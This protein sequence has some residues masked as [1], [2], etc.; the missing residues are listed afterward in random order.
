MEPSRLRRPQLRALAERSGASF[1]H[2]DGGIE[3]RSGL[4]EAQLSRDVVLFP[5]DCVRHNA[6]AT[7]KRVSRYAGEPYFAL[8]SS[9][10]TSLA[11]GLHKISELRPPAGTTSASSRGN[12][13]PALASKYRSLVGL[14]R[15]QFGVNRYTIA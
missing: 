1:L 14:G 6:V 5:V 13:R 3:E 7:V 15:G 4:L 2:H 11:A 12:R 9:G 10:L 8:R